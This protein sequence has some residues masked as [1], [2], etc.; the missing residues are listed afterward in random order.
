MI[1]KA[2]HP[3]KEYVVPSNEELDS[4]IVPRAIEANNFELKPS[5]QTMV[6][7]NVFSCASTVVPNL[8]LL[9]FAKFCGT[10]KCSGVDLVII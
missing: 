1:E 6:H 9:V 10:L 3:L 7:Q 2:N 5:L 4:N 8:H